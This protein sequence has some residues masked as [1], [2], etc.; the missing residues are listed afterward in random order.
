MIDINLT[1]DWKEQYKIRVRE[2]T[3]AQAKHLIVKSLVCLLI[4]IKYIKDQKYQRV[5]SESVVSEGKI[6]DIIHENLKSK[7]VYYYEIQSKVTPQ[8]LEYTKQCY[9]NKQIPGMTCD[10]ILIDLNLLSN[11]LDTLVKQVKELI[12]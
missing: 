9:I 12:V 7:Q 6:C 3:E 4:K 11:D 10:W 8:W 5:Y 2:T 1:P